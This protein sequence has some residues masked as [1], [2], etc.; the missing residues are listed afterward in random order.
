MTSPH[1]SASGATRLSPCASNLKL[2]AKTHSGYRKL[3]A[4]LEVALAIA[5]D[6]A[7][8]VTARFLLDGEVVL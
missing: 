4:R 5:G 3:I 6:P 2:S 1:R 7:P 8:E